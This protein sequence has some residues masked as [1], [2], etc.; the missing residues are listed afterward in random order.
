LPEEK[1]VIILSDLHCGHAT[2]LTPPGQHKVYSEEID[3]KI[4]IDLWNRFEKKVN[5]Y[6][7]YNAAILNGDGIDGRENGREVFLG[8]RNAQADLATI[9]MQQ[10]EADHYVVIKG[11]PYHVGKHEKFEERIADNLNAD[12]F[13]GHEYVDINGRILDLKHKVGSSS[14]PYGIFTPIAKEALYAKLWADKGWPDSDTIIRSHVHKYAFCGDFD[15]AAFTTP[16]LQGTSEFGVLNV[17][18]TIDWGFLIL[19][20]KSKKEWTWTAVRL[21]LPLIISEPIKL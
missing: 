7:P 10:T 8:D 17:S 18:R 15:F 5:K 4:M 19:D 13:G 11:T 12:K 2:G 1:R 6:K 14:V 16:G 9:C 3:D 21:E 20:I